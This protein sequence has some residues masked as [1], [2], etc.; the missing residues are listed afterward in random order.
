MCGPK[1]H[2]G[3][4]SLSLRPRFINK[5][6]CMTY[7]VL[8]RKWRPQQLSDVLGQEHVT[9]TLTNA[10]QAQR[11]AHAF[12][13]AGPR[14]VGKTSAARI[15]AKALCCDSTGAPTPAPCGVC[16]Q[17]TEITEGRSTDVFEIDAASHTG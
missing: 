16:R 11:I 8:A 9:R 3:F 13:F 1:P 7:V 12:L 5:G 15:L 10:I 2:R 4:E 14:G 6:G 17:C